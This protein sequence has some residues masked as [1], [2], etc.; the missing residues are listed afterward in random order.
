MKRFLILLFI[1]TGMVLPSC[2]VG[3]NYQKPTTAF[4]SSFM[5][6]SVA[7]DSV[8]NL[9]WWEIFNDPQ[10]DTLIRTALVNNKNALQAAARV[11]EAKAYLGYSKADLWPSFDYS[12][13]V[14]GPDDS[15]LNFGPSYLT[16]GFNW[17]IDFWGKFR[18]ANEAARAELLAT[19]Y[20]QR[21]VYINLIS[22][23][24]SSYFAY[25]DFQSRLEIARNTLDSR[26][27]STKIIQARFEKGTVGELDL[28]QA[29]IQEAIAAAAVPFFERASAIIETS[30]AIL[31]GANP[32]PLLI[33]TELSEIKV[34]GAIP[35]G[36]PSDIIARR[37]DILEAEQLLIAQNARIGI[38]QAMRFPSFSLTGM[39]GTASLELSSLVSSGSLGWSAGAGLM[40]PIFNFGKNKRR[41]EVERQ[42][43]EQVLRAYEQ[44][45]L[46]GLKDVE[47]ALISVHTLER[48]FHA[49]RVQMEAAINAKT[50]SR[51][52]YDGGVTSYLEVLDSERSQ[53][54]AELSASE[55]YA[56]QL[57]SYVALYKALGGGWI[58]E[59]ER[60]VGGQ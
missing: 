53:F 17:E 49:R 32:A 11:N 60:Q 20:S 19:Q 34:P 26:K 55:T 47:D 31:L 25:L 41:V 39:L 23:V 56:L 1:V 12:G 28:N 35:V 22:E 48:E 59:A 2:M 29:Q 43:T 9:A 15:N 42:R 7:G 51:E 4:T 33:T 38:A 37:P 40:G 46:L 5:Y 8:L 57:N 58:N 10:L 30:L 14:A 3:P 13:R 44:S 27:G 21:W 52:R 6:D 54:N 16:T 50:L 24:A 18:R 36:I 45:I